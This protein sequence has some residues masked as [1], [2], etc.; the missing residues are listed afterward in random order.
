MLPGLLDKEGLACQAKKMALTKQKGKTNLDTMGKPHDLIRKSKQQISLAENRSIMM[1]ALTLGCDCRCAH[2][3]FECGPEKL[4]LKLT[5]DEVRLAI[6]AAKSNG[7]EA[8]EL[9]GGEPFLVMDL[10]ETSLREASQAGFPV[11]IDTNASW[12]KTQA[13]AYDTLA[14]LKDL[15]L[16]RIHISCDRYHTEFVPTHCVENACE[17]ANRLGYRV[18][19][20]IVEGGSDFITRQQRVI[21]SLKPTARLLSDNY[22]F[23]PSP[24]GRG[25][26]LGESEVDIGIFV[27]LECPHFKHRHP[28]VTVFPGC[29]VSFCCEF[30]N[31]RL[32][33]SYT[34][35]ENWLADMLDV[36]RS[37]NCVNA[38]WDLGLAKLSR[39]YNVVAGQPCEYC[40]KLLPE[41]FPDKE[42]VDVRRL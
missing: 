18:E 5:S 10:V 27:P 19:L 21:D 37:D 22:F 33:Y 38:M 14:R 32:T 42:L 30:A 11:S 20:R 29:L 8:I 31:P 36:W 23:I 2:C 4:R 34:L 1:L 28:L 3:V 35:K 13:I 16:R 12:A 7:I 26:N 9:Y 40:F 41:L 15:G 6:Q 17:Q 25:V 39:F 24:I